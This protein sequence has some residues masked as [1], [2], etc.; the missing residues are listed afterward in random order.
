MLMW[1]NINW[2][3]PKERVMKTDL[4]HGDCKTLN[5]YSGAVQGGLLGWPTPPHDCKDEMWRDGVVIN[6]KTLKGGSVPNL[7]LGHTLTYE[8][9]H[10]MGLWHTFHNGCH[11]GDGVGPIQACYR[12][13]CNCLRWMILGRVYCYLD[14]AYS[15]HNPSWCSLRR[16]GNEL[17]WS[18]LRY[19]IDSWLIAFRFGNP[20]ALQ[21]IDHSKSLVKIT[22]HLC[23]VLFEY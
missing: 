22:L 8:V 7:N 19:H 23:L 1:Y 11:G 3:T 6:E 12:W 4:R 5:I 10:W 13:S 16:Y 14:C 21:L 18:D 17:G 20:F 2:D 9:G 15:L